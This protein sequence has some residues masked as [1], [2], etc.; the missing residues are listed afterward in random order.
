MHAAY[1]GNLNVVRFL[2]EQGARL[3]AVE[4][5]RWGT[6]LDIALDANQTKVAEYLASA[7]IPRGR[8][9]P[10]PHRGGK[11]G[12]WLASRTRPCCMEIPDTSLTR[13]SAVYPPI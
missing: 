6:A 12:G 9:I 7:G 2:V 11:L 10:N 8:D 3:D 13:D 1:R 5:D 4:V